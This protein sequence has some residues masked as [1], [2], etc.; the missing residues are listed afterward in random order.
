MGPKTSRTINAYLG[1]FEMFLAF[2]TI[3]RVRPGTVP[4]LAE[5]VTKILRNTKER[6]KG[7]RRTVDLEMRPQRNQRLLDEGDTRLTIDDA[8]KFKASQPVMS[9]RKT[10]QKA[11]GILLKKDEICEA[12]DL[13]ICLIM[14]KT[15]ARPGALENPQLQ[16]Y[17]TMR[18]DPVNGD[19]V[20]LI[21]EHKRSVD[22]QAMLALDEELVDLLA[23]YVEHIYPLFPSPR[24]DY[25]FLQTSGK[26]F[27]NGTIN[28]RLPEMWLHS[29]VRTDLRITA[30][31]IRKFIVTVL[32]E[33]KI[34][35]A[36]FDESG[37][38]MA[39]CHT[40]KTAMNCYL[41]ED[42][43][44][45]AS[46]AARTIKQFTDRSAN[47]QPLNSPGNKVNE[48]PEKQPS[49]STEKV[50][51]TSHEQPLS[52]TVNRADAAAD[53][54]PSNAD[55]R[56]PSMSNRQPINKHVNKSDAAVDKQASNSVEKPQSVSTEINSSQGSGT[57]P[58]TSSQRRPLAE[59]EKKHIQEVFR[60]TIRS[61]AT[62]TMQFVR[63]TM[64]KGAKLIRIEEIEGMPK[65]VVDYLR[66]MQKNEPRQ[67][68][69]ELPVA[70]KSK[71]VE[72]WLTSQAGPSSIGTSTS[73]KQKWSDKD[74][75]KIVNV[76]TQAFGSLKKCH[77][78]AR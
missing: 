46:R 42:L 13:L 67:D 65:R 36:A 58:S 44:A 26:R 70:E 69:T 60:D 73:N 1:A 55:E 74:T 8:E 52:N 56:G 5:E 12:R 14:I 20:M 28:R 22:G 48:A 31:N 63:E 10:I 29:G 38:R 32:Q 3:D 39:M 40:Q 49:D 19:P 41:R 35:G 75:N 23:I 76:F 64:K 25:L 62:I 50:Q 2:A 61:N 72:N 78:E 17:K 16:H 37:V 33:N 66:N 34:E 54:Q 43:T 27:T 6:L 68:P 77:R 71:E 47:Y 45:V 11:D 7:L 51:S 53:N 4:K 24:D 18:R 59:D 15:G 9:V 57:L 30:M 21:P